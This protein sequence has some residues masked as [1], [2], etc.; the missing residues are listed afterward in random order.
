MLQSKIL[1]QKWEETLDKPFLEMQ[2][3]VEGF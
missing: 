3:N 2:E 1:V